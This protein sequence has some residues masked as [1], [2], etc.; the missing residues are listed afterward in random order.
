MFVPHIYIYLNDC[1]SLLLG[2]GWGLL[3]FPLSLPFWL[4]IVA[5]IS[6]W[7]KLHP[8]KNTHFSPVLRCGIHPFHKGEEPGGVKR[9]SGERRREL[10]P[11]QIWTS[12]PAL[13]R[14][15]PQTPRVLF[16]LLVLFTLCLPLLSAMKT[17]RKTQSCVLASGTKHIG[18]ILR[19]DSVLSLRNQG[20]EQVRL[21]TN[22]KWWGGSR[23]PS[24]WDWISEKRAKWD[25]PNPVWAASRGFS[26]G[27]AQP[28]SS[29][30]LTSPFQATVIPMKGWW[31]E[32]EAK[33]GENLVL[34]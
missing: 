8:Y 20:R 9:Q 4:A 24:L 7:E 5:L 33:R 26:T 29:S 34:F 21:T 16:L 3:G 6:S 10:A 23:Q 17:L 14:R 19:L 27:H 31:R 13:L 11:R 18:K 22:R 12:L 32:S 2:P 25:P 1:P 30:C 15:L 28:P